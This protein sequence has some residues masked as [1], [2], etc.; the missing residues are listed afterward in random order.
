[1]NKKT[2]TNL[3]KAA[4]VVLAVTAAAVISLVAAACKNETTPAVL[5][6]VTINGKNIPVINSAG[7]S[8]EELNLYIDKISRAFNEVYSDT[9]TIQPVK[10]M[11][12]NICNNNNFKIIVDPSAGGLSKIDN[13]AISFGFNFLKIIS[14]SS[15]K[16][17]INNF[18]NTESFT[19]NNHDK[20]YRLANKYNLSKETVR[21]SMGRPSRQIAGAAGPETERRI[22]LGKAIA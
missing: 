7:V 19:M 2:R 8:T 5:K 20:I 4:F 14:N 11:I 15:L 22:G 16:V 10:D 13:N 21:I 18:L 3:G 1:M 6:P 9:A 17:G 12:T